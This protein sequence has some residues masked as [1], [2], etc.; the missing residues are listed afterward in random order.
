MIVIR[1][2]AR[3]TA[4]M[5]KITLQPYIVILG[6]SDEVNEAYVQVDDI[7]YKVAN[8]L[9]AIDVCFKIFHV[10][11][12]TYPL[13]SEH[14]WLLIQKGIYNCNTKWDS[15]IPSTEYILNKVLQS[16]QKH[17]KS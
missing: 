9:E 15:I 10:F 14:I 1:E 17:N 6:P 2:E 4:E 5:L 7:L 16:F 11:E 12:I 3:K 13:M 8:I